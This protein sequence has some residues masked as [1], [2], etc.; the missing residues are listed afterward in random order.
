MERAGF[1]RPIPGGVPGLERDPIVTKPNLASPAFEQLDVLCGAF[2][3]Q[4]HNR[5]IK[6]A[7]QN[8][9]QTLAID[10]VGTARRCRADQEVVRPIGLLASD[11]AG[12]NR[13]CTAARSRTECQC[14][15]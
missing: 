4:P 14:S 15:S 13:H 6:D 2:R 3:G 11:G 8:L 9:P 10:V 12:H 1:C 7:G 5:K